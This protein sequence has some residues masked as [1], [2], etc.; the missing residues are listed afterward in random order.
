MLVDFLPRAL[1]G[2]RGGGERRVAGGLGWRKWGVGEVGR[3]Q[4]FMPDL[5]LVNHLS[6]DRDL[7]FLSH[8]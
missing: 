8:I 2:F 6:R 1:Q 7:F 4:A 3:S 5:F